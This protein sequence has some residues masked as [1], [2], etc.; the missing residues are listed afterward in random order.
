MPHYLKFHPYSFL[1]GVFSALLTL[2]SPFGHAETQSDPTL[3]Y[4]PNMQ[5]SRSVTEAELFSEAMTKGKAEGVLTGE[6]AKQMRSTLQ[7]KGPIHARVIKGDLDANS[8]QLMFMS[9]YVT[10][11]QIP[12]AGFTNMDYMFTNK[13]TLCENKTTP[14]VEVVA[15]KFGGQTCMPFGNTKSN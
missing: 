13:M 7:V 11:I 2:A 4:I 14:L 12:K 8:C 15:C 3:D 9:M 6:T 1:P 5:A 10:G